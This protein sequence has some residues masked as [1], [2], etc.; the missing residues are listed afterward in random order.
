M[1]PNLRH[2][3]LLNTDNLVDVAALVRNK[4]VADVPVQQEQESS[5]WDWPAD[6]EACTADL[7]FSAAH[8]ES[9][10]IKDAAAAAVAQ[11]SSCR[12]VAKHD[13]YWAEACHDDAPKV[14]LHTA[15]EEE[16]ED[17]TDAYWAETNHA[18]TAADAYWSESNQAVAR[19]DCAN[20]YWNEACYNTT[21]A[22]DDYWH[23][24]SSSS[25]SSYAPSF[26][27][28]SHDEY[29]QEASHQPTASDAY[30]AMMT[31]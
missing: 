18:A 5:Y 30:W 19:V 11:E 21:T 4:V 15:V 26:S 25:S 8:F 6:T 17:D 1:A 7:L 29:W 31:L 22:A 3:Q 9:N 10:L 24:P 16:E 28:S 13:D 14:A 23:M 27:R 20:D 2:V 12:Q